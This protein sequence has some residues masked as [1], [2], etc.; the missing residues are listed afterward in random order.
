[1]RVR[2]RSLDGALTNVAVVDLLPAGFQVLPG[3]ASADRWP[4]WVDH[5]EA[6][7][8]RLVA[9]GRLSER[10]SELTYRVRVTTAGTFRVPVAQAS[11]MYRRDLLGRTAIGRFTVE[12][13]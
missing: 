6:R 9:Y 5:A 7:E 13:P 1:M 8:D 12:A 10:V 4:R 2:V 11:D 3:E